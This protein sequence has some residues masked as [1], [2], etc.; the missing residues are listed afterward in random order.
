MLAALVKEAAA[1]AAAHPPLTAPQVLAANVGYV[2]LKALDDQITTL[3]G[4]RV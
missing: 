2:K 1:Y 3:R 4:Q